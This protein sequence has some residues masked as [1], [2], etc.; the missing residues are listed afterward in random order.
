MLVSMTRLERSRE[1]ASINEFREGR[2]RGEKYCKNV[3]LI[4]KKIFFM[5]SKMTI[6]FK[7]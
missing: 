7:F 5:L 3:Q 2:E 6:H 1:G 4:V